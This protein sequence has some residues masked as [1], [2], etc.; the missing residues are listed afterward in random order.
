MRAMQV[1]YHEPARFDDLIEVYVRVSRIGRTSITYEFAAYL[2][3][4]ELVVTA[5]Q[6]L[7]LVDLARRPCR[8]RMPRRCRVRWLTSARPQLRRVVE[9]REPTGRQLNYGSERSSVE[10]APGNG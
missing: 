9:P 3:G 8:C 4:D 1:E 7:V 10:L 5:T 6:T 2:D